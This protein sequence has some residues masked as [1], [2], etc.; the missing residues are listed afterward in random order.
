VCS[1]PDDTEALSSMH[2]NENFEAT[3]GLITAADTSGTCLR[4]RI[5]DF[6][7]ELS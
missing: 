3:A 5:S 4:M 6:A 1:N 2:L 7:I